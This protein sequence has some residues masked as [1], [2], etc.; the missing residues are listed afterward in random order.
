MDVS[1]SSQS[2][3]VHNSGITKGIISNL[4]C[5]SWS[6]ILCKNYK[7][8]SQGKLKLEHLKTTHLPQLNK[9]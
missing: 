9:G 3:Q 4:T 5:V 2:N 1:T 7:I 8:I 6:K